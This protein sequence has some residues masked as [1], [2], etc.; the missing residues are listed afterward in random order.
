MQHPIK[1]G[2]CKPGKRAN[3]DVRFPVKFRYAQTVPA[4]SSTRPS[5]L[6]HLLF[7]I[8]MNAKDI[9]GL[10]YGR[11]VRGSCSEFNR[12]RLITRPTMIFCLLT[13]DLACL[14]W[15]GVTAIFGGAAHQ[16]NR[17]TDRS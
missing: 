9:V 4:D 1:I 16:R 8:A 3:E 7:R 15:Y 17:C 12:E 11:G 6:R 10:A 13:L 5:R 2:S 14:G